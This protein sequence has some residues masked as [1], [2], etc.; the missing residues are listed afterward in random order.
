MSEHDIAA[1]PFASAG[2]IDPA[3]MRAQLDTTF[4]V[5]PDTNRIPLRLVEVSDGR[6]VGGIERFS[7]L[8]HGPADR[9]LPQG[10][11]S[12]HHD[13][14]GPLVLFIVPVIGSNAERIVYE[15]CFSRP[16]R[17]ATP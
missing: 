6:S 11:Y 16:T 14:L 12:F 5:G 2:Q 17:P 8:F 10:L 3:T 4:Q 15:A 9:A 7:L 1:D 13:A